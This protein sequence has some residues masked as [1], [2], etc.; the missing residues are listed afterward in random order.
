MT[1]IE[2]VPQ[3]CYESP[4]HL[5]PHSDCLQA[6]SA[7]LFAGG[8]PEVKPKER[9]I[10]FWNRFGLICCCVVAFC[11]LRIYLAP[12]LAPSSSNET[13][14]LLSPPNHFV[15]GTW[16]KQCDHLSSQT[17]ASVYTRKYGRIYSTLMANHVPCLHDGGNDAGSG[18]IAD[19]RPHKEAVSLS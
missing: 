14:V 1:D 6:G 16:D 17:Q 8:L 2:G 19:R 15:T 7:L 3:Q 13:P 4:Q 12:F 11:Q 10:G 5:N 18:R 9:A